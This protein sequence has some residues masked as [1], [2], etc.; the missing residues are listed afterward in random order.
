MLEDIA[1][2]HV[3]HNALD[4]GGRQLND[5]QETKGD[6]NFF[7]FCMGGRRTM[8]SL[9]LHWLKGFFYMKPAR[10]IKLL[11]SLGRVVDLSDVLGGGG[12]GSLLVSGDIGVDGKTES[13]HSVDSS[14]E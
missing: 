2:D 14:S 8:R 12:S 9:N 4:E 6:N 5:S 1:C 7:F 13:D 11:H 10:L 3:W